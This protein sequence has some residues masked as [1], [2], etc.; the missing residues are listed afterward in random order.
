MPT[1]KRRQERIQAADMKFLKSVKEYIWLDRFHN[2]D[3]RKA[4]GIFAT[5]RPTQGNCTNGDDIIVGCTNPEG[6]IC[7][8]SEGRKKFWATLED[9]AIT[10]VDSSCWV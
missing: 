2:D 3:I 1:D 8:C 7:V 9:M 5:Y 6:G 10:E 4:L